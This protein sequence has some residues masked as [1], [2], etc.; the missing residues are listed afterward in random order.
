MHYEVLLVDDEEMVTTSLKRLLRGEFAAIHEAHSGLEALALLEQHPIDIVVSDFCMPQ[1]NGGQLVSEI[2]K[3]YP[4]V[5]NVILSGQTPMDGFAQALNEGA[6][7]K[8]LCKPWNNDELKRQLRNI[9]QKNEQQQ[10]Y[11]KVTGMPTLRLLSEKIRHL[12]SDDNTGACVALIKIVDL[13]LINKEFGSQVG[14]QVLVIVAQRLVT[15]FPDLIMARVDDDHFAVVLQNEA[16][17][18]QDA[19]MLHKVISNPVDFNTITIN[20]ECRVGISSLRDWKYSLENNIRRNN[21][22]LDELASALHPVIFC[23]PDDQDSWFKNANF[24]RELKEAIKANALVLQYQPQVNLPNSKVTGCEALLRWH[25]PERGTIMPSEFIPLIERHGMVKELTVMLL[26]QSLSF[27]ASEPDMFKQIRVSLNLYA[28]QLEDR[29]LS[30]IILGKLKSYGVAPDRLELEITE[31]NLISSYEEA[32]KQLVALRRAGVKIAIDDFGTGYA[33][34]ECLCELPIDIIKIDGCFIREVPYHAESL[35]ALNAMI[36]T[37]KE[38]DLEV[39]VE[40]VENYKQ[41]IELTKLGVD[42]LQGYWFSEPLNKEDLMVYTSL[43]NGVHT[44]IQ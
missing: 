5:I 29:D 20:L 11:D 18:S 25:H 8:F 42:R 38:L 3:R 6:I 24:I 10:M 19:S 30:N 23:D 16:S 40:C 39:V 36:L 43:Y 2:H 21:R 22:Q 33:T 4:Q 14:N 17:I 12:G 7:S 31:T 37:A 13:P 26:D 34:Y 27:M 32:R 28:S 1:M 41:V 44:D 35:A 15:E 9:V